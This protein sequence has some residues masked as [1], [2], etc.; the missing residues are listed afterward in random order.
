MRIL[1]LGTGIYPIPPGGYGGVERTIAEFADALRALGEEVTVLNRVRKE[2]S[3]DEYWFARELPR[4]LRPL[5]FD[6]LHASTPVVANRL[7]LSGRPYVFTSHS[8]HWFGSQGLSQRFGFWLERRAVRRA[9]ATI[10]LT[11]EIA[12]QMRARL[13]RRTPTR[14]S[15]IPI[16]VDTDRFQPDWG[17]RTGARALG[18][19]VVAPVKRWELAAAG[20]RG[21]GFRLRIAGPIP[22]PRYAERVRAAGDEVE[23]LGVLS[24]DELRQELAQADLLIHPS[25]QEILSGAVLQAMASGLAVIGCSPIARLVEPDVTGWT[26][27]AGAPDAEIVRE[28]QARAIALQR[29]AGLRRRFGDAARARVLTHYAWPA[30]AEAH[31]TLYRELVRSQL[32]S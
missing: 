14:L 19:G 7:A 26:V 16:G 32:A 25:S 22:D 6:V 1:L 13:G 17:A 21:T 15:V 18:I 12:V 24:D 10:A 11:P 29:D 20:V 4:L 5:Q 3:L 2:R 30:V 9:T 31:R 23:L 8:R 27:R 28:L